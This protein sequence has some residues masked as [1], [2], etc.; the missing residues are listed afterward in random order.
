MIEWLS[1]LWAVIISLTIW[2]I[3]FSVYAFTGALAGALYSRR[4]KHDS[5]NLAW[6]IYGMIIFG[7]VLFPL[8][9]YIIYTG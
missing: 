2:T 8:T 3:V 5:D 7:G 1:E 4:R 6:I 9:Y